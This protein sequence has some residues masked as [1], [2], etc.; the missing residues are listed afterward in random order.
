M[1]NLKKIGA[2]ATGALFVGATIGMAS[3]ATVPSV[4]EKSMLAD[5]SGAATAQLV[6]G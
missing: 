2:V 6:V 1:V 3:A 5:S 4:F